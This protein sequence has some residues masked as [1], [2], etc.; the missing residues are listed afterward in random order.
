MIFKFLISLFLPFL[1][2][3]LGSAATMPAIPTWYATLN[4][5]LWQPPNWLFGPVWT[6]LYVLMGVAFFLVIK[7]K[8]LKEVKSAIIIFVTQLVFNS[9]WSIVFFGM[10][11]V[12]GALGVIAILWV[13]IVINISVFYRL[14]KVAG[15]LLIPYLLWVSFASFLNYTIYSLN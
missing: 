8:S 9:L 6:T 1:A 15:I 3:G 7:N 5:P 11:N 14:N 2:G 12:G 4:K 10:Q 13:L